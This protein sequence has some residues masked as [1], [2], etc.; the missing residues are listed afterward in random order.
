[1]E[2]D[3][4]VRLATEPARFDR[5]NAA[6]LLLLLAGLGVRLAVAFPTHMY[7]ADADSLLEGMCADKVLRGE[8]PVFFSGFRIGSLECH[9]TASL[10]ALF[11]KSRASLALGPVLLGCLFL[12]LAYLT[13][14]RLLGPRPATLALLFFA[15]PPPA[16]LFWV[17]MPNGYPLVVALCAAVLW[18]AVRLA[19]P[20][21]RPAST[22]WDGFLF[23]LVAGLAVWDSLQTLT[24]LIPAVAWVAWRRRDLLRDLR[25]WALGL[26]GLLA[27]AFPWLAFNLRYGWPSLTASFASRPASG[28]AAVLA[29]A[30]YFFRSSLPELLASLDPEGSVTR[31]PALQR[32][33]WAP[34]LAIWVVALLWFLAAPALG[35]PRG[36]AVPVSAWLLLTGVAVTT[37][38]VNVLSAAGEVRGLTVRYTLPLLLAAVPALASF[39]CAV[40]RGGRPGALLAIVL[41]AAIVLFNLAGFRWPGH[42]RRNH[43]EE[44]GGKQAAVVAALEKQRVQVIVGSLWVVYPMTFLSGEKVI[45]IPCE[46][47]ADHYNYTARIG[48]PER[49]LLL[50]GV[51]ARGKIARWAARAGVPGEVRD[52]SPGYAAFLPA[53]GHP[54]SRDLLA[55]IQAA[56]GPVPPY[57]P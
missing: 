33:L 35:R 54:L 43:L 27:G 53:A 19:R 10:F 38:L 13:L 3:S 8:T 7:A 31:P 29:N 15:V 28:R 34:V 25:V 9:L 12:G 22:L 44:I 21:S 47:E 6:A 36:S 40:A 2:R 11:G 39:L 55:R 20:D 14:R 23:G 56:C 42:P 57:G 32:V 52:L 41:A 46:P 49:W 16:V 26:A 1:M 37:F 50:G 30:G 51:Q 48:T 18:A 24:C 4:K 17:Y 5:S 45:G